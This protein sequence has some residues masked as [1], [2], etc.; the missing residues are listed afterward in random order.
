M[1][2]GSAFL[3]GLSAVDVSDLAVSGFVASTLVA[4]GLAA[5]IFLGAVSTFL[6]ATA[7]LIFRPLPQ[8]EFGVFLGK[9]QWVGI[10]D[11]KR[12]L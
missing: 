8:L 12:L 6:G 5:S 11:L 9:K 2:L 1:T 3:A 10:P 4:A 7:S